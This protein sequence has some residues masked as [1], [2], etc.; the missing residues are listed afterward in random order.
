MPWGFYTAS[1]VLKSG[2]YLGSEFEAGTIVDWAGTTLPVGWLFCDGAAV[3]RTTYSKLFN[4]VGTAYGSGDGSTTFNVPNATGKIIYATPGLKT[5]PSTTLTVIDT[6]TFTSSTLYSMPV[7]A[8][9]VAVEWVG[10]GGGGGGGSRTT[11][12]SNANNASYATGGGGG[13]SGPAGLFLIK[14]GDYGFTGNV[15]ITIGAGGAGGAA[16][17]SNETAGTGASA[18]SGSNGGYSRIGN[19]ILGFGYGGTGGY[20]VYNSSTYIFT[21][22]TVAGG[23]VLNFA[24]SFAVANAA[25]AATAAFTNA[26]QGIAGLPGNRGWIAG[27][28]G[29]SG[30]SWIGNGGLVSGGDGGFRGTSSTEN[31]YSPT[32]GV[33]QTGL[34]AKGGTSISRAGAAGFSG[35]GGGGGAGGDSSAA[36]AGG[37]GGSPGGGGGGGGAA[38]NNTA[39]A[40]GAGANGQIK[41]W[42]YG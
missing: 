36:G 23:S 40:G 9:I 11:A 41:I 18:T 4:I 32:T 26:N 28:G 2:E 21:G 12:L 27:G 33:Q 8:K 42:V 6:Q 34:G 29:G 10:A 24:G 25:G 16:L 31:I 39:G 38:V 1:G 13:G 7:A 37:A 20:A 3:S 15:T 14:A 35:N 17:A 5:G 19:L 22:S 30:A